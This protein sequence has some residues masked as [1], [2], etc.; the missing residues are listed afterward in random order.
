MSPAFATDG[1]TVLF[2][3]DV[4][5]MGLKALFKMAK[6]LDASG[7]SSDFAAQLNLAIAADNPLP[8]VPISRRS[9]RWRGQ[10][11]VSGVPSV[12]INAPSGGSDVTYGDGT[13]VTY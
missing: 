8:T 12:L 6:G 1:D 10:G 3:D 2:R 7:D 4:M 9:A 11:Q 5:V 13:A